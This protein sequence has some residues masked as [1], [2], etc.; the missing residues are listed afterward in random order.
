M[1]YDDLKENHNLLLNEYFRLPKPL[2][3]EDYYDYFPEYIQQYLDRYLE[4]IQDFKGITKE[5]VG[6]RYKDI[7][8]FCK[9]IV[10][11]IQS[12]YNGKIN[13]A[14]QKFRIGIEKIAYTDFLEPLFR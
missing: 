12:Y 5:I 10:S 1:E 8:S 9:S 2:E 13:S 3:D 14:Y 6:N 7:D 4:K 11:A